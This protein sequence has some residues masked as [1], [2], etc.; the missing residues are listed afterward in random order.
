[1]PRRGVHRAELPLRMGNELAE[2]IGDQR[3]RVWELSREELLYLL[4]RLQRREA[5]RP[6]AREEERRCE[7]A[8]RVRQRDQHEPAARPHMQRV[9]FERWRAVHGRQRE[10]LVIVIE[11]LLSH[12]NESVSRKTGAKH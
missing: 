3:H 6:F 4:T 2:Q 1:M 11:E 7:A 12:L 5:V 10:L 8:I 9:Y